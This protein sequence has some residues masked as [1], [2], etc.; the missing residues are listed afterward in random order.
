MELANRVGAESSGR[1]G[2]RTFAGLHAGNRQQG[3]NAHQADHDHANREHYF[4]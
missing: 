1:I 3:G 4:Q 2:Y